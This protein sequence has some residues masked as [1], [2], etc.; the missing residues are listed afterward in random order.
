MKPFI[1]LARCVL[2]GAPSFLSRRIPQDPLDK[3]FGL[4]RQKGHA[5]ENPNAKEFF[6][7]SQALCVVQVCSASVK[8][9]C[10][11]N[12]DVD[13]SETTPLRRRN[14]RSRKL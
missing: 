12:K 11:G 10:R 14:S 9:N 6:K 2:A 5:S 7:S 8:G 4:Q 3:L 13:V 1:Q